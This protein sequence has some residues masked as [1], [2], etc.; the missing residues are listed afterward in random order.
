MTAEITYHVLT[1]VLMIHFEKQF[2]LG[3]CNVY[4][5]FTG[6]Q[7]TIIKLNDFSVHS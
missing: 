6:P 4:W 5:L 7:Q 3:Y 1:F 2:D